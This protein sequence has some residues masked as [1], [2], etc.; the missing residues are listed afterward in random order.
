[1][2]RVGWARIR[3]ALLLLV[4][5]VVQTTVGADLRIDGV[6]PDFM[7][8]LAICGGLAC[9]SEAGAVIGFF[10]GLLSDLAMT[11]TPLG[12]YALSWCLVGWGVGALRSA[13]LPEGRALQPVIG[14]LATGGGLVVFLI[15]GDLAGQ[16]M[17]VAGGRSYL[18]RVGVVEALWNAV[19]VVPVAYV[20][21]RAAR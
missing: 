9:G 15:A 18:I 4:G 6:A 14:L 10:A 7:L 11:T 3:V 16:T 20:M 1:M 2:T 21:L 5:I 17:L 12:L 8:L 13:V 19:L